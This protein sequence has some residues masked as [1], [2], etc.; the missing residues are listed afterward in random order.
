MSCMYTFMLYGTICM[1]YDDVCMYVCMYVMYDVCCMY[2]CMYVCMYAY[3]CMYVCICICHINMYVCMIVSTR[4][5]LTTQHWISLQHLTKLQCYF[6]I[7][8]VRSPL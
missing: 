6:Q 5:P 7:L 8:T 1:M 3:V 2:V 4:L